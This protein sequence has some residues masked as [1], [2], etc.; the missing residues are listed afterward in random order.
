MKTALET[1]MQGYDTVVAVTQNNINAN[2][3]YL[4]KLLRD[5]K[6]EEKIKELK[7]KKIEDIEKKIKELKDIELYDGSES[8]K[9]NIAPPTIRL[10]VNGDPSKAV[11]K[12]TLQEGILEYWM[13]RGPESK[14]V[15]QTIKNWVIGFKV[16]LN[17]TGSKWDDVPKNIKD[18]IEP[19]TPDGEISS[20]IF[21]VRQLFMD[22]QNAFL[23]EFDKQDTFFP[24]EVAD[25]E[26]SSK[27]KDR[28]LDDAFSNFLKH[29]LESCKKEQNV[30]ILGYSITTK[31]PNNVKDIHP[32][33]PP[34]SVTFA[35]NLFLPD[36]TPKPDLSSYTAE[37]DSNV[38]GLDTLNFL[39]MTANRPQP[40]PKPSSPNWFGNWVNN[41][42]E[43]GVV[44]IAKQL[45]V[46]NF[47]LPEL[48]KSTTLKSDFKLEN[49]RPDGDTITYDSKL[50]TSVGEGHYT[51]DTQHFGMYHYETK[52]SSEP[53]TLS[54]DILS[55]LISGSSYDIHT[56]TIT[57]SAQVEI[58]KG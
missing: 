55:T 16:D 42:G 3:K 17:L 1:T 52:P 36:G 38:G 58:L 27:L 30:D 11:F 19:R 48:A 10:N 13:G 45:F 24:K 18:K 15:K 57:H 29:Y 26:K 2:F 44:A 7:E 53:I 25:P 43:Y 5:K 22:F 4:F 21:S 23:T 39:M 12:L 8:I 20:E 9:A 54:S 33:F 51:A 40:S 41:K 31:N 6:R 46:D 32:S 28:E 35:T 34:T 37:G 47:L 14:L 50:I 56:W 49:P